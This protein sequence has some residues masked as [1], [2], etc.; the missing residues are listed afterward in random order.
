MRIHIQNDPAD[1]DFLITPA[2]WQTAAAEEPPHEVSFGETPADFDPVR[3]TVE[4]LVGPPR[5]LRPLRPLAAPRLRLIF[6]NAAGVDGLAPFD[7]LPP[8]VTL[9]NNRGTHGPK[10]GEYVAMAALLLAARLPALMVAQQAGE[11]RRLPAPPLAGRRALVIGT[12]DLGS[13]GA[14]HLRAL[15]VRTTG[16][17]TSGTAHPDFDAVLPVAALDDALPAADLLVL[18]CPLTP[19]TRGLM[20]AR[21]LG[22]LAAKAAVVNI[23]RGA[24]IDNDALCD[25]LDAER[26]A[27]AVL[28]VFPVE[29]LPHG[30]R[31]WRT[32]NL[33]ATPHQS[34][35]DPVAYNARA[36]AIL[37]ANLRALRAGAPLPNRVDTERGY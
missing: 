7:W 32:R 16:L 8:G 22:L 1:T 26:L 30:H 37:A 28:D 14:R 3:A 27:G 35:D 36:L 12:G 17:N 18:A 13:A 19:A 31:I 21:R 34:C 15:G 9:L 33:I 29:P 10:A 2:Q 25:M 11:W 5:S 20:D 24:L 23:G 4:V 6:S